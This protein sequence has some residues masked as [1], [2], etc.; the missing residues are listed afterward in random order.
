MSITDNTSERRIYSVSHLNHAARDLLESEFPLIW[1][2]GEISNLARP[3]SGHIYFSLK[4]ESAQLRCAMF[5]MRNRQVNFRPE[6][7]QQILVR[8]RLSLYPARG[9]Y[10]LIAEH[11]EEAGDGALRRQFELLK[12]RL[13]D[14]GLFDD[15][16]KQPL[17]ELPSRLGVI[18]SPTGAAIRD[19]ISVLKRRFPGIP[20]LIYPVPVQGVEAPSAIVA[21]LQNAGK[22]NECDL[23]ILARG[24]GSLEDLWAF[25]DEAVARAIHACPLP[26]VSAIGHEVDF[27]IA[28]FVADLRAPTP[29][30]AAELVSPD[31]DE[32]RSTL[33]GW[34]QRLLRSWQGRIARQRQHLDW[35]CRQLKH[36][37]QRLRERAQ[38]LDELEQR[39]N[40]AQQ[41]RLHQQQARLNTLRARL[42]GH[43]PVQRLREIRL[44]LDKLRHDNHSTITATLA[45]QR[46]RLSNLSRALNAVSPL[47]TL[48]RGYAIVQKPDGEIVRRSDEVRVGDKVRARLGNGQLDCRVET[49]HHPQ[50]KN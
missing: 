5:K 39:L 47:A 40:L 36:P 12:H 41:A 19:I 28:D 16:S 34:Q 9:D 18:T 3:A 46:A 24:G 50:E 21:A 27:T 23:L 32:W 38:R 26:V 2:E 37:G 6:N 35:L 45:Q 4:D 14:E 8:G 49:V 48:G 7:G 30:A 31:R 1:V 11:M 20:V 17:P 44:R 22:R 13:H 29:S 25:N 10:Q 33:T 42:R 43:S 15:S